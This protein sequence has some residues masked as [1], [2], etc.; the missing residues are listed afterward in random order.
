MSLVTVEDVFGI[1]RQR[2]YGVSCY[3]DDILDIDNG[4]RC[5]SIIGDIAYMCKECYAPLI[6]N[7]TIIHS[8]IPQDPDTDDVTIDWKIKT[9]CPHCCTENEFNSYDHPFDPNLVFSVS[10]L[11]RKGYMV[12]QFDGSNFERNKL[13]Y[14]RFE[15]NINRIIREYTILPEEFNYN[16]DDDVN[17]TQI[18]ENKELSSA[19]LLEDLEAWVAKLP[20]LTT[21]KFSNF[22]KVLVDYNKFYK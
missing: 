7:G 2:R 20:V 18:V 15:K 22:S 12:E 3:Y 21:S 6:F 5:V 16:S 1:K 10:I 4:P 8:L 13:A 17:P 9:T 14:I 11:N 19:D